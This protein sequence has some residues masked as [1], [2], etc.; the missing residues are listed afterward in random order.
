M[1]RLDSLG[2]ELFQEPVLESI[3]TDGTISTRGWPGFREAGE[4]LP[5]LIGK[6]ADVTERSAREY[7]R[8]EPVYPVITG[9]DPSLPDYVRGV[10]MED[11]A[12]NVFIFYNPGIVRDPDMRSVA[13][14]EG[15]HPNQKGKGEL[16]GI[17][18]VFS[19]EGE[20]YA[21]P[22]GEALI[23][24]GAEVI[25]EK[26][27]ESRTGTYQTYY[28]V[29]KEIEKIYPLR[30]I[31]ELAENS[32]PQAVIDVLSRPEVMLAVYRGLTGTSY[33]GTLTGE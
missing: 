12:G 11:D 15:I 1:K 16:Q 2:K 27:G 28:E 22:I 7:F 25:L 3:G 17:Y 4:Y 10:E 18:A 23:E 9:F 5:E 6:Q 19:H 31:Y 26:I 13:A 30:D 20:E 29:A 14:H 32:G 24:G 8:S 21:F 33:S